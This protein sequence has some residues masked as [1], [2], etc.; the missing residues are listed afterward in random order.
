MSDDIRISEVTLVNYR[1]YY[2]KVRVAFPTEENVFAVLVGANGA[3]KS[4][5][6][7][8]IHWCLF[9]KEPHIKSS[10]A[11]S[12]INMQYL[13]EA[14]KNRGNKMLEMSVKIIMQAGD[15]KYLIRRQIQGLLNFLKR[16]DNNTL[17]MSSQDPVPRGFEIL[18]RDNST[19]FQISNK[20]GR[21]ETL[22][23]KRDFDS[24]VSEY[25]IPENLSQFFILD[26]EFLQELFDKFKGIKLGIDQISQIHILNVFLKHMNDMYLPSRFISS[27]NAGKI[28]DEIMHLDHLLKSENSRGVVQ[29]SST[30]VIYGTDEPMHAGGKPLVADLERS[31]KAMDTRKAEVDREI[32]KFDV[33][34]KMDLKRRHRD[35]IKE[36]KNVK[37]NLDVLISGHLNL[38]VTEGPFIMCKSSIESA[39]KLIHDEMDKGKLPNIPRRMLVNDLLAKHECLC[40]TR[41]DEG[42]DARKLVEEEMQR[43]VYEAQYDIANDIR[44]HNDQFSKNYDSLLSR[45]DIEMKN[46]HDARTQQNKLADEIRFLQ[47]QL[48]EEDKD[49]SRLIDEQTELEKDKNNCME[50]LAT[51]KNDVKS[52]TQRKGDALR[53][54]RPLKLRE[55]K[56]REARLLLEKSAIIKSKMYKIQKDVEETI[57]E[58]VSCETL[59]MFNNLSWKKNYASLMIDNKYRIQIIDD[60]GFEIMGG[61]SAG[62]KLFLALSFIMALK[63]VTN[64]KF[65]F[66]IDSPLGKTGGNLRIRFGKNM[67]ELLDGSQLIMLATNTEYNNN[68]IRPEDGG[69]EMP[70]L[71]DLLKEKVAIQEYSIDYDKESK[72]AKISTVG[73]A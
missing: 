30:E 41:L 16:D 23:D 69:K 38:L 39:T 15:T 14:E 35:K 40:G 61:M 9:G 62:E 25:I 55:K 52:F 48:P 6:W 57:R 49:Y 19:L 72:T 31:I 66:V 10:H 4:N 58:K 17:I 64:H 59:K 67:P 43:I 56:E 5:F 46:I 3:G 53:K 24:L 22:S 1:Q 18:H 51:V 26:G 37:K 27:K 7:N 54:L 34:K 44:Y 45:M 63:R 20:S 50:Y 32:A 60:A 73:M 71:I 68:L 28:G 11:P 70:S 21:W 13:Y 47:Q 65:P 12:I 36:K 33:I 8:A 42:T 2:G 29:T